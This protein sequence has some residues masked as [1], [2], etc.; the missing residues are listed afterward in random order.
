MSSSW[1]TGISNEMQGNLFFP[2][3]VVKHWKRLPG[4]AVDTPS[5]EI[6]NMEV[7]KAMSSLL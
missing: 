6:F 1:N 5:L 3:R 4:E 2:V 7:D